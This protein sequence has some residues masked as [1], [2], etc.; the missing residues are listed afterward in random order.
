MPTLNNSTLVSRHVRNMPRKRSYS[1][2][3]TLLV[4]CVLTPIFSWL[5]VKFKLSRN[6]VV[7]DTVQSE[8]GACHMDAYVPIY[9]TDDGY[10]GWTLPEC[11]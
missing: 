9:P 4:I 11:N 6:T 8:S 1:V 3:L 5:F 2:P 10:R 7:F